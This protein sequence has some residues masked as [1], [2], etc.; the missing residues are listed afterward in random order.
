[1]STSSSSSVQAFSPP[2]RRSL[3]FI[4]SSRASRQPQRHQ[5]QMSFFKD[6]LS[7]AFEND[8]SLSKDKSKSQIEGP[9]TPERQPVG[10]LTE[11]QKAWRRS[12]T[13]GGAAGISASVLEN[14]QFVLDLFLVGIPSKDPSNDLFGQETNISSRD[15]GTGLMNVPTEPTIS[16]LKITLEQDG[17]CTA[18]ATPFTTGPTERGQWKLLTDNDDMT[19]LRFSLHVLGYSRTIQ[20]TGSIQNIF[21]TKEDTQQIA[22]S[23]SYSIPP[24]WVFC[25]VPLSTANNPGTYVLG[26]RGATT[27]QDGGSGGVIRLEKKMGLLGAASKLIACGKFQG[28]QVFE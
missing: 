12:N 6:M 25:D 3:S 4:P 16:N 11:V 23:T 10:E 14:K 9:N 21:W 20:T 13:G 27:E 17:I 7:G 26:K 2:T 24:G 8:T 15:K 22:T 28:K 5:L 19:I 18:D 1:M